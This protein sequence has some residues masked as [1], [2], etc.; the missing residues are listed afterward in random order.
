MGYL[1]SILETPIK[2]V[3]YC[4]SPEPYETHMAQEEDEPCELKGFGSW[5]WKGACDCAPDRIEALMQTVNVRGEI[6][7]RVLASREWKGRWRRR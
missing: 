3:Q 1:G 2:W 4:F 5:R 6:A 7:A